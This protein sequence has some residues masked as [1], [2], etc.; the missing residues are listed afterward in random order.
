M[1][2]SI[3]SNAPGQVLFQRTNLLQIKIKLTPEDIASLRRESREFV[4]GTVE[5]GDTF[6]QEVAIHLKGA[7]GSFRSIDDK[8]GFTIDFQKLRDGQRFFGL[9]RIHLN[10]SVEDPSY[11]NEWLGSQLF[12]A[13]GVPAPR[14]T[15]ALVELNGRNLGLYV[16]KEGYTEDFLGLYFSN[17]SGGLFEPGPGH[18]VNEKLK[19][20]LGAAS[21]EG[22]KP[23]LDAALEPDMQRRCVR[24]DSTLDTRE[25]ASFVA[26]EVMLNHFDG[27][28]INRNNFR[29]YHE[30]RHGKF[31]F[32]PHGMDQL[33]GKVDAPFR[34]RMNGLVAKASFETP[35]WRALYVNQFSN[36]F[37]TVFDVPALSH[38]INARLTMLK[39]AL[40]KKQAANLLKEGDELKQRLSKRHQELET[41]LKAFADK[42][43]RFEGGIAK[44]THWSPTRIGNAGQ[45]EQSPAPDGQPS[46]KV[47]AEPKT[48]ANWSSQILLPKGKY[49]FE[50]TAQTRGIELL[51]SGKTKGAA[52]SVKGLRPRQANGLVG[53]TSWTK[54]DI[55]FQITEFEQ[56]ITLAC[57]LTA[58]KGEA[59]FATDSVKLIRLP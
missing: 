51:R 47:T 49:R 44:L 6:L 35:Q 5:C 10:N 42:S 7:Q 59:W 14:V 54:L 22:L 4:P 13:A 45:L 36:L 26:M 28:T 46:L 8:P 57:E 3:P 19:R 34:P 27:Y 21:E 11:L 32:I 30:P 43:V 50:A 56:E 2:S 17:T 18:D 38:E 41:Q 23:L 12:R 48:A 24:L 40:D 53:D 52:L 58:D 39:P 31:Y 15:H 29:I 37:T 33:L 16:L 55:E 25:F 9:R 20:N 1:H